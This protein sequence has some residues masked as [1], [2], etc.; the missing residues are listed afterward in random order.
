VEQ[1]SAAGLEKAPPA[2]D[3]VNSVWDW[4]RRPDL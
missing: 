3:S 1:K 4:R 2:S